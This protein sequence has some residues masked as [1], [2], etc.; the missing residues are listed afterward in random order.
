[1]WLGGVMP[2]ENGVF[3]M[4]YLYLVRVKWTPKAM[5]A[6]MDFFKKW[7][8]EHDDLCKANKVHCIWSGVSYGTTE[9]MAFFYDTDICLAEFHAF[10][11][12]IFALEGG[13]VVDYGNTSSFLNWAAI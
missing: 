6:G 3:D 13:D 2:D 9:D 10:K 4:K 5:K 12:K 8:K 11:A 7:M 1:M